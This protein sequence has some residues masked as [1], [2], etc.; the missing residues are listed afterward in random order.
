MTPRAPVAIS[1]SRRGGK[2][3]FVTRPRVR[4]NPATDAQFM[5]MYPQIMRKYKGNED[6]QQ[7]AVLGLTMARNEY[8]DSRGAWVPFA[9]TRAQQA[10]DEHLRGEYAKG[11][12]QK[13]RKELDKYRKAYAA[14]HPSKAPPSAFQLAEFTG[15]PVQ[16]IQD[17]M[18][19][20]SFGKTVSSSSAI[21]GDEGAE[22][23]RTIEDT[24][25]GSGSLEENEESLIRSMDSKV[26]Q[27]AEKAMTLE[28]KKFLDQIRR[29]FS[30]VATAKRMGISRT[31]ATT[32]KRNVMA[33]LKTVGAR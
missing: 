18:A 15:K 10:V 16:E 13:A 12:D 23:E 3:S 1:C 28:E 19:K 24:L 32:L 27:E 9:R 29:G 22:D 30:V 25:T 26:V 5:E 2:L 11:T 4:A 7:S 14:E 33:H 8:D 17:L 21:G 20:A 31:K 6:I